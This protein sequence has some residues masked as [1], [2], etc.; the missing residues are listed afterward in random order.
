LCKAYQIGTN[1]AMCWVSRTTK[2]HKKMDKE[3][4]P[5][6]IQTYSKELIRSTIKVQLSIMGPVGVAIDEM[7][8][9]I[10]DRIRGK[11]LEQ[12]VS[13]LSKSIKLLNENTIDKESF[14]S[15]EFH[16]ILIQAVNQSTKTR[17]L[18]KIRLFANALASSLKI[19]RDAESIEDCIQIIDSLTLRDIYVLKSVIK[20]EEQIQE[21]KISLSD[22]GEDFNEFIH[23]NK[24][25]KQIELPESDITFSLIKL[26]SLGLLKEYY[27]G[28]E[29]GSNP[30]GNYRPTNKLKNILE[31]ITMNN[32]V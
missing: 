17:H 14:K 23:I 28:N 27:P 4:L 11:R 5:Q 29:F 24:L 20:L 16:D 26:A 15:E 25:K 2:H 18:E 21:E 3:N 32:N 19:D 7:L 22:P 9:G 1:S 30:N 31:I 13:E 12:F 10:G 8:F 6:K